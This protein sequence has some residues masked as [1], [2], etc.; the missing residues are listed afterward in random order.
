MQITHYITADG[1]TFES[2]D[3][4]QAATHQLALEEAHKPVRLEFRLSTVLKNGKERMLSASSE[5]MPDDRTVEMLT[6]ILSY[7]RDDIEA[8]YTALVD[9][10]IIPPEAA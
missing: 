3:I 8:T 1:K 7:G 2:A 5:P 4:D 9:A 6:D 10:G